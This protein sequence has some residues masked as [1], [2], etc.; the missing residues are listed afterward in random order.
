[1]I[2]SGGLSTIAGLSFISAAGMDD[3]HLANLAG[4]MGLGALLFLVFAF[5]TRA[6]PGAQLS[7][8]TAGG[9]LSSSAPPSTARPRQSPSRPRW[10]TG[11][12]RAPMVG[13]PHETSYREPAKRTYRR[14]AIERS[15]RLHRKLGEWIREHADG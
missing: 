7:S 10:L 8:S 12:R 13:S 3:A 1:M 2:I 14:P 15:R 9:A 11:H 6:T 5:R 4:Y